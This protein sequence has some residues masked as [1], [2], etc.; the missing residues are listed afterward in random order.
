MH[1]PRHV[2]EL[3]E[4]GRGP[5]ILRSKSGHVPVG[6]GCSF[7]CHRVGRQRNEQEYLNIVVEW[8]WI[9]EGQ[10]AYARCHCSIVSSVINF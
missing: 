9:V 6:A 1:R 2:G 4:V 3:E 5:L 10:M 8:P 7:L